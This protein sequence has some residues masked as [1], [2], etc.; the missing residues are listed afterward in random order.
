MKKKFA[1]K[2]RNSEEIYHIHKPLN[3]NSRNTVYLIACNLCWNNTLAVLKLSFLIGLTTI[4]ELTINIRTKNKFP[5]K[6]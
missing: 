6:L 2:K 3:C 1:F 5:K 4:K